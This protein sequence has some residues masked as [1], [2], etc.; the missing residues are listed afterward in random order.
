MVYL[1][2]NLQ[3][4][5]RYCLT[6]RS[7]LGILQAVRFLVYS[8]CAHR[9]YLQKKM[10]SIRVEGI[11]HPIFLRIGSTDIDVF[12]QIF[13]EREYA[14]LESI[15]KPRVIVDCGAYVGYSSIYFLNK[16]PT[17]KIIAI[18][19]DGHNFEIAKINLMPY[20]DRVTLIPAAIWGNE[21]KLTLSRGTYGDGREWATQVRPS[22][23]SDKP[24]TTAIT[25]GE[26][27]QLYNISQI[28]I[29][30]IDIE[31]SETNVFSRDT[32]WLHRVRNIAIE[33]HNNHCEKTFLNAL[34]EYSYTK[35]R[36]GELTICQHIQTRQVTTES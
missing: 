6:L 9:F 22:M 8:K 15:V 26:I 19:P 24:D 21:G 18:E 36:S 3:K 17:S 32:S 28:D 5:I 14:P 33:L 11:Q 1:F 16:F 2:K 34:K 25:I 4:K 13:I 27:I 35:I 10:I 20:N 31:G 29:L 23:L 30:K 7:T 12:R